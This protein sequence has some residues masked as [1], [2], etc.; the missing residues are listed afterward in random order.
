[1][2]GD[3]VRAQK[4]GLTFPGYRLDEVDALLEAVASALD[5]QQSP[6]AI[7]SGANLQLGEKGYRVEEVDQFLSRV[8]DPYPFEIPTVLTGSLQAIGL[9]APFLLAA[10]LLCFLIF[11]PFH[12]HGP[13]NW[14][15]ITAESV[16]LTLFVISAAVGVYMLRHPKTVELTSDS[17]VIRGRFKSRRLAWSDIANVVVTVR[18]GEAASFVFPAIVDRKGK[19]HLMGALMESPEGRSR[20]DVAARRLMVTRDKQLKESGVPY[21]EG[22]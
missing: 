10:A 21:R 18:H 16:L 19:T 15:L 14:K 17:V 22:P 6:T 8:T 11:E 5:S 1:M 12:N 2:D 4:F 20:A 13:V 9:F 3:E 7:I